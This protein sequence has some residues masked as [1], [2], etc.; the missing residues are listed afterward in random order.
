[1]EYIAGLILSGGLLNTAIV[2]AIF[3]AIAAL[4]GIVVGK[5]LARVLKNDSVTKWT[6]IVFIAASTQL[7]R[8]LKPYFEETYGGAQKE[9]LVETVLQELEKQKLF[10]VIFQHHPEARSGLA[11]EMARVL[12][13]SPEAN[14]QALLQVQPLV[15]EMVDQYYNKYLQDAPD[16][17]IA[18]LLKRNYEALVQFKSKPELCVGYYLG[19]PITSPADIPAD[20]LEKEQ[21][22]KVDIIIGA[23]TNPS[24]LSRE[25]STDEIVDI[26]AQVYA[27]KNYNLENLG[28]LDVIQTLDPNEGCG[29]AIELADVLAS[30]DAKT[31]ALV[32][33]SIIVPAGG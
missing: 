10:S 19:L 20:F 16:E 13:D 14:A 12:D 7:P 33:K 17:Q 28:K 6:I 25:A 15:T 8:I 22:M 29:V 23:I 21:N 5:L 24:P 30:L 2:G 11:E 3:G 4:V 1:M 26:L 9:A 27:Q 31:G 32:Y 18:A